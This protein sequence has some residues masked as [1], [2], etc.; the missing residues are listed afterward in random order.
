MTDCWMMGVRNAE[1]G[2]LRIRKGRQVV[3]EKKDRFWSEAHVYAFW[4]PP[5]ITSE[6]TVFLKIL[7][8]KEI[9]KYMIILGCFPRWLNTF[10]HKYILLSVKLCFLAEQL[11]TYYQN[12][13]H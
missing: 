8:V 6:D 1:A 9:H 12:V 7:T 5:E 10:W 2:I 13:P 4:K 3:E 11:R